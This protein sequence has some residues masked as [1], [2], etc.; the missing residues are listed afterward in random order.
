MDLPALFSLIS[1]AII[2]LLPVLLLFGRRRMQ[3]RT[4][5]SER[6]PA[7]AAEA[8]APMTRENADSGERPILGR[9]ARDERNEEQSGESARERELREAAII[10]GAGTARSVTA[11]AI[12]STAP[13]RKASAGEQAIEDRLAHLTPMQRAIAYSEILGRPAALREPGRRDRP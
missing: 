4:Q 7:S 8:P 1:A 12:G 6:S 13:G 5:S 10:A 2:G 9:L 11:T 3:R